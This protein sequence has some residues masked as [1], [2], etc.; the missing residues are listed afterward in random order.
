[1]RRSRLSMP[2]E[3]S[4]ATFADR[5]R[6][7]AVVAVDR[8][9]VDAGADEQVRALL[10]HARLDQDAGDLP[11]AGED[12][13]RPLDRARRCRSARA[14]TTRRCSPSPAERAAARSPGASAASSRRSLCRPATTT[15]RSLRPRP[16]NC[17]PAMII[18]CGSDSSFSM[19]SL[20]MRRATRFVDATRGMTA[21]DSSVVQAVN[22]AAGVDHHGSMGCGSSASPAHRCDCNS[23]SDPTGH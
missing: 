11:A 5:R 20:T 15:C 18:A 1:M 13:V 3:T 8:L 21:S 12:V 4:R 10:L 9:D 2:R 14:D 7:R 16:A 6:V 23:V 19:H 22:D 17:S